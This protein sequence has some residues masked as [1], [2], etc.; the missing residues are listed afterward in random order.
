MSIVDALAAERNAR[1]AD[2]F[3]A[4]TKAYGV[5]S[6]EEIGGV[7][8]PSAWYRV[9]GTADGMRGMMAELDGAHLAS[10]E[11]R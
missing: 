9:D 3:I 5:G 11:R 2:D 7:T 8:A 10:V 6:D 4:K 1:I